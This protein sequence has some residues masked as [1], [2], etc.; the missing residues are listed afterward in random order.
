M[1]Q[2]FPAKKENYHDMLKSV[3]AAAD[4]A[5]VSQKQMMRLQLGFEEAAINIIS[6]AYAADADGKV[7]LRTSLADDMFFVELKDNGAP[8]NPLDAGDAFKNR[9][10]KL[11]DAKIGGLGIA[12]LRR[13]FCDLTYRYCEEDGKFF[14]RLKLGLRLR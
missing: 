9:P 5:G 3:I 1:W 8:F 14:N 11:S 4:A 10:T 2:E 12:F 6:Y 13:I 7:W